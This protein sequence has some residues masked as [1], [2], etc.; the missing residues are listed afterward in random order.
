MNPSYHSA[1]FTVLLPYVV[2][3]FLSA[4]IAILAMR[5]K[6][7]GMVLSFSLVLWSEFAWTMLL[8]CELLAPGLESKAFW[9]GVQFPATLA[10]VASL[11]AFALNLTSVIRGPADR[12]VLWLYIPAAISA[13]V[14]LTPAAA[15]LLRTN[16][17]VD[18]SV[19]FGELAYDYTPTDYVLFAYEYGLSVVAVILLVR[20]RAASNGHR[21]LGL[22]IAGFAVPLVLIFPSVLGAR[23]FSRR[24]LSPIWF[25]L[26]NI[27]ITFG[28][29]R[30]RLFDIVPLA[31]R[32]VI[33]SLGDPIFVLDGDSMILD[34]NRAFS[35]LLGL[36][37]RGFRGLDLTEALR[38][39]SP[40]M[41]EAVLE[42][43]VRAR[44][45]TVQNRVEFPTARG[46]RVYMVGAS[47]V[48]DSSRTVGSNLFT[49][50]VFRDVTDLAAV[51][52]QLQV[53]NEE[54]EA[55]IRARVHDLE[56]EIAR[57]RSAEHELQT[58]NRRIVKSQH[59]I[60][61]TLS[62]LVENRS[63]ETANHVLRVGEYARILAQAS[64]LSRESVELITEAAPLHDVGKIAIPDRILNKPGRLSV[65]EMS[66]M[67][68]HSI[69]GYRIL[70]ASERSIIRVAAIMAL[71]H[72]EQWSGQGYPV[73]KS[74]DHIS[75]PGRIVC[76]CDVFDALATAR[77]Y[78]E[79]WEIDRI[80]DFV[81]DESG[82]MFD[83]DLVELFMANQDRF[84][85]VALRYPDTKHTEP[86][87]TA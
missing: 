1:E 8:I 10:A 24:D 51:E 71:E 86:A 85:E 16:P 49:T 61:L 45:T 55:R 7:D 23:L 22:I 67:K 32:T 58:A 52:Q 40:R 63:P 20:A 43:V 78:K 38:A 41:G 56:M 5:H 44:D 34:C 30:F 11:L 27:P 66:I 33:D 42:A 35:E 68:T 18:W 82:H 25:M 6:N 21:H 3:A 19:P 59:E 74:K 17:T 13:V 37:A 12:R 69:V 64:G 73:G 53:W 9:D 50:V 80:I 77:P 28:L 46:T 87:A 15:P 70:G 81:H 31:R 26:G 36:P 60:L 75:L 54:L 39:T 79:A 47:A 14:A 84:R 83:P 62:E 72:H 2:S 29:I 48:P 76:I 65:D 57:R 4:L